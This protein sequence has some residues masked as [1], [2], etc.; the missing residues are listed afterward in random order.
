M[1]CKPFVVVVYVPL[2][3]QEVHSNW[4]ILASAEDA[5]CDAKMGA[6]APQ[7]LLLNL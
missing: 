2:A 6:T 4:Q 1:R 3:F 7:E 5:E